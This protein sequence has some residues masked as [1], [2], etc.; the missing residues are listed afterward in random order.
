MAKV[1]KA[2]WKAF[3]EVNKFVCGGEAEGAES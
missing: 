1:G 2:F 3:Q